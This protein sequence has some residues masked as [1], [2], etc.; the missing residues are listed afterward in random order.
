MEQETKHLRIHGRVQGVGY[1]AWM[2]E[3]ASRMRLHGWVRNR[4]DKTVE[5]VV[6]GYEDEVQKFISECYSG[7]SQ[8]K[9]EVIHVTDGIDEDLDS[10][11]IR[12]TL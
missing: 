3:L 11:E 7:P 12:D 6:S 10:F 5:A 2:A 9:V 4:K 1:R 8:A